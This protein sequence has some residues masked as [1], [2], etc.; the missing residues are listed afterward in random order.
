MKL[1]LEQLD[2]LEPLRALSSPRQAEL[3][4]MCRC[5]RFALGTDPLATLK[6]GQQFIYVVSGE[7]RIVQ[8]DGSQRILVGGCDDA[9]WPIGYKTTAPVFSRAVTECDILSIDHDLVDIM[10][11]WDQLT[12]TISHHEP[13]KTDGA[14]WATASGAFNA[15]V[16]ASGGFAS[17]TPAQI[18]EL[19]R[20]FERIRM[21]RGDVIIAEGTDGDY[22]YLIESGRC[23]VSKFIGGVLVNLAELKPGDAFGEE[24]LV[25]ECKRAATVTM[26]SDGVLLRLSKPDFVELL[27]QPLVQGVSRS[28]AD[29]EVTAGQ[30]C[31]LDVRYPAEFNADG[32]PGAINIPLSEIRSAFGVLEKNRRYIVY[33]HS[34]RRSAAATFLLAQQGFL[35]R[36]LDGGLSAEKP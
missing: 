36:C 31:W 10:M 22:Y 29:N 5:E 8:Q 1:S 15:Q 4:G 13:E 17:L 2:K 20:R 9:N 12:T 6:V 33:C 14:S 18:H 11:T 28:Q 32:L 23:V 3:L 35:V 19:L 25:S 16:L 21:K 34:G 26:K 30:A 7:L 24:A 27:K